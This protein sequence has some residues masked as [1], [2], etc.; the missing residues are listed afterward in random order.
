MGWH[1]IKI[2]K[3]DF[4]FSRYVR[5]RDG[6][7]C[8]CT[9]SHNCT[10]PGRTERAQNLHC[11]HFFMRGKESVRRDPRNADAFCANAHKYV[12]S[13]RT[14]YEHWKKAQMGEK[15][16][17]KLQIDANTPG[18]KDE[19]LARLYVKKLIRELE[20]TRNVI[21]PL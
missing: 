2:R 21:V 13:H 15:D 20:E 12:E 3:S 18:K 16:F 6:W 19:V 14:E 1:D 9:L 4:M 7:R 8:V 11:S 10:V 17:N 5:T